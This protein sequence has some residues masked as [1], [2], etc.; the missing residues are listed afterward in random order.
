MAIASTAQPNPGSNRS[1]ASSYQSRS[2]PSNGDRV[3][4]IY[5]PH[6]HPS[7]LLLFLFHS[8]CSYL[9]RFVARRRRPLVIDPVPTSSP[10]SCLFK[11]GRCGSRT[12]SLAANCISLPVQKA[13][14]PPE[15]KKEGTFCLDCFFPRPSPEFLVELILTAHREFVLHRQL[16]KPAFLRQTTH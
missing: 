16:H 10:L 3:L 4:S 7:S 12:T 5:S 13:C 15:N 2:L 8:G 9:V 11:L 1:A 14:H 6:L